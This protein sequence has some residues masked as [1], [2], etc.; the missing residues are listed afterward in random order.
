M[1]EN[2]GL[3]PL[4]MPKFNPVW[5]EVEGDWC[6]NEFLS[7]V[8]ITPLEERMAEKKS[9]LLEGLR[10]LRSLLGDSVFDKH[11]SPLHN[12][13]SHEGKLLIVAG[14]FHEKS[15]LER[16]YIPSLKEAFGVS[17]VRVVV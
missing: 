7:A 5:K 10:K 15:L 16:D 4:T 1:M 3:Q 11:I 8:P 14:N 2:R 17:F 9:P 6:D 12:L 13:T